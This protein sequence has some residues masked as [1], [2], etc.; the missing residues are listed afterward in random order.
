VKE[1]EN[2]KIKKNKWERERE[3]EKGE[4]KKKWER[5]KESEREGE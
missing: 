3:T 2:K 1:K 4:L 5:E